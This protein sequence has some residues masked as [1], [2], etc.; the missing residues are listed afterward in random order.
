[1]L[2]EGHILDSNL[3]GYE[4]V[5]F[6]IPAHNEASFIGATVR[7][8]HDAAHSCDLEYEVIV[9]NDAS[10]DQTPELAADAGA[11]VVDVELRN[12]GAVRNAGAK[13]A[14]NPWLFF[15]DADTIMPSATLKGALNA[16]KNGCAG[17]GA[18]VIID[19]TQPLFWVKR[20]MYLCVVMIW[21][22]IGYWAAGCFMYC[23][24]SVFESFGGFDEKFFAAEEL[25]FSRAVKRH[26]RFHLVRN[27]VQTSARKLHRYST[28]ELIRF[29]ISPLATFWSPLKSRKG[30]DILYQDQR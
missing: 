22:V 8:I 23:R 7:A 21:Q 2:A 19:E 16:M 9:V 30:L 11:S 25:F 4:K 10:T 27:P 15:I 24:K 17:G 3:I 14:N 5:S 12:I 29:V 13:A 26:G 1:M 20:I 18:R 6:V 28:W